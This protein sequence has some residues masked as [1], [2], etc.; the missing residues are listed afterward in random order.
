MSCI[1][2]RDC[3]LGPYI[4]VIRPPPSCLN[5]KSTLETIEHSLLKTQYKWICK[6]KDAPEITNCVTAIRYIFHKHSSLEIPSVFIGDMPRILVSMCNWSI[7]YVR[8][9]EMELGDLLF[10]RSNDD[11]NTL[12]HERYIVH[13]LMAI[14][15]SVVF[16]SSLSAGSGSIEDLSDL[17]SSRA[18]TIIDRVINDQVRFMTYIDPRNH[19]LRQLHSSGYLPARKPISYEKITLHLRSFPCGK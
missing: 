15:H 19:K 4:C 13:V 7:R 12:S 9:S 8:I 17:S 3:E 10:L 2:A 6:D 18:C 16:H 5:E 14:G 11:Q 1:T